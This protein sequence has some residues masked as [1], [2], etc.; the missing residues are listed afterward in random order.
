MKSLIGARD[1]FDRTPSNETAGEYLRAAMDY[2][3]EGRISDDTFRNALGDI[4]EWL[5]PEPIE[6][7]EPKEKKLFTVLM[8]Q[9]VEHTASMGIDAF[10]PEEAKDIALTR[11]YEAEWKEGE[12]SYDAEAYMVMD[13]GGDVVWERG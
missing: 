11:A 5:K 9:Y 3:A 2:E 6:P 7:E 8:Q 1:E 4:A 10:S 13:E 12:D